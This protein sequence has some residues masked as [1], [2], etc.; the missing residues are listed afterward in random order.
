MEQHT[1]WLNDPEQ[2]ARDLLG[3]MKMET[4]GFSI[5]DL[6]EREIEL[7][8]KRL[9]KLRERNNVR[10]SDFSH[11]E[12]RSNAMSRNMDYYYSQYTANA[13]EMRPDYSSPQYRT[14]NEETERISDGE[15]LLRKLQFLLEKH[16]QSNNGKMG[17]YWIGNTVETFSC[18]ATE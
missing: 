10:V 17:H 4:S 15:K 5:T 8:I 16:K 3:R 13:Y 2:E 9:D 18:F 6:I 11:P 14:D 1:C 7:T 12:P